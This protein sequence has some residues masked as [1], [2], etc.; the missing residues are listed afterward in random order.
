MDSRNFAIGI[1]STTA[2]ILLVGLLIINTRP[3]PVW[4]DGMTVTGGDYVLTVGGVSTADEEYLYVIDAPAGKLISYR[5]DTGR[6]QVEIVQGID[7]SELRRI[8]S[9]PTQ[10]RSGKQDSRQQRP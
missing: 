6:K 9:Q 8:T 4:A 3:E 5:F 1:L 7:L 10:P 2:A